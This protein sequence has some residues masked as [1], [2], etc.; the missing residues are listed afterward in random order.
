MKSTEPA[1]LHAAI[2]ELPSFREH[3]LPEFPI[4]TTHESSISAIVARTGRLDPSQ[5]V[6]NKA[7]DE[8]IRMDPGFLVY[9]GSDK[10][11]DQMRNAAEERGTYRGQF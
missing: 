1:I 11:W 8:A 7:V 3:I 9:L 10:F 5:L 2:W 6:N 4:P